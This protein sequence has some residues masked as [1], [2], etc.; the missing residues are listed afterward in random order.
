MEYDF[1]KHSVSI[2]GKKILID[3]KK[4]EYCIVIPNTMVCNTIIN[5]YYEVYSIEEYYVG[6]IP[7]AGGGWHE[8]PYTRC[9][10]GKRPWLSGIITSTQLNAWMEYHPNWEFEI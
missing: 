10:V 7:A 3:R 9:C 1:S 5:Y 8:K 4:T 6:G 2:N